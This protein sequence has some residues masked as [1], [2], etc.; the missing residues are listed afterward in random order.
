MRNAPPAGDQAARQIERFTPPKAFGRRAAV[1]FQTHWVCRVLSVNVTSIVSVLQLKKVI[2]YQGNLATRVEPW[3]FPMKVQ[4]DSRPQNSGRVQEDTGLDKRW[5]EWMDGLGR[6]DLSNGGAINNTVGTWVNVFNF[7]FN[8]KEP[9][10]KLGNKLNL[11]R[12]IRK[13]ELI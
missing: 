3:H 7:H 1:V 11:K 6:F 10:Q 9:W 8:Y 5:M 2:I 13:K 4:M 12:E